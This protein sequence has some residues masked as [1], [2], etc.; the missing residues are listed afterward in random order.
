VN[1][2]R[3]TA[4]LATLDKGIESLTDP[5]RHIYC[6]CWF[7]DG[8][9]AYPGPCAK[10]GQPEGEHAPMTLAALTAIR[11]QGYRPHPS[12]VTA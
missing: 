2:P 6:P 12:L 9:W 5:A 3:F 10:C 7:E 11:A 1:E 8:A 4:E